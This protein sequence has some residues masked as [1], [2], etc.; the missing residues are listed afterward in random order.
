VEIKEDRDKRF[1]VVR[2]ITYVYRIKPKRL[3]FIIISLNEFTIQMIHIYK[4]V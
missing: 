2:S 4:D 3:H 1:Y